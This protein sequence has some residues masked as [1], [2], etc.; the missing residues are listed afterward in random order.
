MKKIMCLALAAA[1]VGPFAMADVSIYGQIRYG[2]EYD[3][4]NYDFNGSNSKLR[5]WDQGSRLGFKGSDKLDSGDT[6]IWQIENSMN[7]KSSDGSNKIMG[8]TVWGGRNTFIGLT[9]DWG[10]FRSGVYDSAY[11]TMLTSSKLSPLFDDYADTADYKGKGAVFAQLAQRYGSTVN[12]DSP[13]FSGF[14]LRSQWAMDS[15]RM[16]SNGAIYTVSGLYNYGGFNAGLAY[17]YAAN[18]TFMNLYNMKATTTGGN[19]DNSSSANALTPGAKTQGTELTA[20]YTF[21][22][23]LTLG[24]GWEHIDSEEVSRTPNWN[25]YVVEGNYWFNPKLEMQGMYGYSRH[26][27]GEASQN[28]TQASLGVVYYL[29][30]RTRWYNYLT[31]M[32]NSADT[33]VAH[34]YTFSNVSGSMSVGP[35]QNATS[36]LSGLRTDF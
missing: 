23:G 16:G 29:S 11:K 26:M 35:D 30:K 3:H 4:T 13:V 8:G 1:F 32:R 24:G 21:G 14:Q 6:L 5:L 2:L 12:Y 19:P 25:N 33:N 7:S 15:A 27:L 28:G 9:G 10:T 31:Y 18:R 22:N 20:M 36:L 17:E 34:P